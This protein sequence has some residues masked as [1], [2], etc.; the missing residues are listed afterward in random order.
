M[1]FI[2]DAKHQTK[3]NTMG[4][5]VCLDTGGKKAL[6]ILIISKCIC[7]KLKSHKENRHDRVQPTV[8]VF[9]FLF[10]LSRTKTQPKSPLINMNM[11]FDF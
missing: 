5:N 10:S 2:L 9:Y 1:Q 11:G 3:S 4:S 6:H 7:N 8:P